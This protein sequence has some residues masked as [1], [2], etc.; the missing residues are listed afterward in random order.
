[1]NKRSLLVVTAALLLTTLLVGGLVLIT[2]RM[3]A[4]HL[5]VIMTVNPYTM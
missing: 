3:M 5:D 4:R 2:G 1:M